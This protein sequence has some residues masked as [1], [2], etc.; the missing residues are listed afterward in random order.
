MPTVLGE[1]A[2]VEARSKSYM[3]LHIL[4]KI[5][6]P[7]S[8]SISILFTKDIYSSLTLILAGILACIAAGIPLSALK[9]YVV[10]I[11]SMTSFIALSFILFTHIPGK[12]L[13]E[14]VLWRFEAEKGVFEWRVQVTDT[15]LMYAAIF[16]SRIF[17][18][19][20]S[21]IL[22][23]GTVTDRDLV[24][25]L[26]SIGFPFGACVAASLFFRG[27]QFFIADF[28]TIREA[29]MAR[30][31]DFA[32]TPL[33]KKFLLY[34]NALIPLLSLMITRSYEVSLAL[35]ARGIAPYTK[36]PLSY[37]EYRIGERDF[38][39]LAIA[40]VLALAYVLR[41]CMW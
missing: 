40:L 31:V 14:A 32:R 29:M 34:A 15:S 9:K 17:A 37:H 22:L 8:I 39:I 6:L 18:M 1:L 26:R 4:S 19:V 30:G 2:G 10:V 27:I 28:H 35:E 11:G 33:T 20:L 21:A 12:T 3:Q 25:G 24:W 41:W 36:A 13:Y 5:S 23:L 7:L 38:Y 16:I